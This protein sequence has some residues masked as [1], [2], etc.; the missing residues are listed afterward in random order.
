MDAEA[1]GTEQLSLPSLDDIIAAGTAGPEAPEEP[2]EA[3]QAPEPAAA[4]PVVE[5]EQPAEAPPQPAQNG[6]AAIAEAER[7]LRAQREEW[8]AQRAT[9]EQE[10]AAHRENLAKYQSFQT[11]L[12]RQD[13]LGALKDMGI[14]FNDLSQAVLE[15]R[16]VNPTSQLEETLSAKLKAQEEAISQRLAQLEQKQQQATLH[17]FRTD[18]QRVVAEHS[19]IL[20][21]FGDN[22]VDMVQARY[23]AIAQSQKHLG[24]A[25]PAFPPV[26]EVIKELES[27]A[28]DFFKQFVNVPAVAQL[29]GASTP[30]EQQS[31]ARSPSSAAPT[32]S[33]RI[34]T[35]VSELTPDQT[36]D[37]MDPSSEL[38]DALIAK[39][40]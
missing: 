22:A 8:K 27:E 17:E 26:T 35:E 15:Q 37:S 5:P 30:A 40:S 25:A 18:T 3:P 12:I 20:S 32:L 39:H 1:A 34:S 24:E 14:S 33:N 2:S 21:G 13:A 31:Q 4:K 10:Q 7:Q 23:E 38:L 16:G 11:K 9:W 19:P 6:L 29:F 36:L 28:V